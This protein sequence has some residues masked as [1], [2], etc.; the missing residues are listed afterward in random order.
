M[1]AVRLTALR[2]QKKKTQQ[3]MADFL[4][5]T[6]PAYTAY[7]RGNRNP[8]YDTLRKLADFF[9]VTTDYL[10]GRSDHP[11]LSEKVEKEVDAE[12]EELMEIIEGLP[13]DE[14]DKM[15]EKILAYAK[16]IADANKNN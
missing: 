5:V 13:E 7:E 3:E 2:K 15:K 14:K 11:R 1:L 8:D 6:R 4:G 16:G 10:L 12:V 9:D